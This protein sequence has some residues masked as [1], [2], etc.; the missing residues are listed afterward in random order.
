VSTAD[1]SAA[2]TDQTRELRS[3]LVAALVVAGDITDQR[4][5]HV[6][7]TVPRHALVPRY[8]RSDNYQEIDGSSEDDHP[9]WLQSV[10]SD[11]TLITQITPYTVTSS[12]TMPGLVALMLRALDVHDHHRVLQVGTGTGYTA[13]LL[14]ERLG[15]QQVTTIDIDPELVRAASIRLASVGYQPTAITGNGA[16]GH[17]AHAPFD[18][19]LATCSLHRIPS[20][21]LSQAA[22]G[23][24][25]V[26]PIAKGLIA[27]DV[28]DED[29]AAGR[30]LSEGGYFMPLRDSGDDSVDIDHTATT[31]QDE[32]RHTSLGPRDTFY[33]QHM[34]FLLT[35]ALPEVSVGQH[36]PSLDE[37]I[38]CDHAGST[39]RLDTSDNGTFVVTETGS[40]ALWTEVEQLHQLWQACD[41]PHRERFGLSV[42]PGRQWIW[43][44]TP[45][46]PHTWDLPADLMAAEQAEAE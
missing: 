32:P 13:A 36:G 25:I 12:G 21:W 20:A 45:D 40:R 27:L 33:Q 15:S 22:P 28:A 9:T 44:D 30:F 11:E 23:A 34:R 7:A 1:W 46:S 10:Y 39:A 38:I 8:Y 29:H 35:V 43:L 17:P 41:Q 4:W 18:R 3:Q 2:D 14:C 42:I 19:F 5:R 26:A 37:L 16:H 24:R 31:T 6:F